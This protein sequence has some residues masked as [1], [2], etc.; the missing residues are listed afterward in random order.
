MAAR[1]TGFSFT[2]LIAQMRSRYPRCLETTEKSNS[3][4][5]SG[6]A[7]TKEELGIEEVHQR[8]QKTMNTHSP[9]QKNKNKT[10]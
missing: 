6:Q 8:E 2:C 10:Y 1:G 3:K 4:K 5:S 7:A 9:C